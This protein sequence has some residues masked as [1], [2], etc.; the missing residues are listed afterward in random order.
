M[1]SIEPWKCQ[2]T[3]VVFLER[4]W[5]SLIILV[6]FSIVATS[7]L[8]FI[9]NLEYFL[10]KTYRKKQTH[11]L[12]SRPVSLQIGVALTSFLFCL[13]SPIIVIQAHYGAFGISLTDS[14]VH[15]L[16][17]NAP[18]EC[19]IAAAKDAVYGDTPATINYENAHHICNITLHPEKCKIEICQSLTVYGSSDSP[20]ALATQ[21][22]CRESVSPLCPNGNILEHIPCSCFLPE[23]NRVAVF[24][25]YW[26]EEYWNRYRKMDTPPYCCDGIRSSYQCGS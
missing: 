19:Y 11:L 12:R 10:G 16:V 1:C 2:S 5:L 26:F 4:Y 22:R 3:L 20:E 6:F 25:R 23:E 8:L 14:F 21:G 9:L 7:I 15:C 18:N 13:L 24:T 17:V